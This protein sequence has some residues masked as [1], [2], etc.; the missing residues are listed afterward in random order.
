MFSFVHRRLSVVTTFVIALA[1]SCFSAKAQIVPNGSFENYVAVPTS[2]GGI[3]AGN[4]QNWTCPTTGTSDYFHVLSSTYYPCFSGQTP[5]A[6]PLVMVP[7]NRFGEQFPL[8]VPTGAAYAG[9]Y[10]YDG[11]SGGLGYSEYLT[12]P[13]TIP[14]A[15]NYLISFKASLAEES[16]LALDDIGA[17]VLSSPVSISNDDRI[18]ITTLGLSRVHARSSMLNRI[19]VW[20]DVSGK[21]TA[22]AIGTY[23]R[24][25]YLL[26]GSMSPRASVHLQARTPMAKC[27]TSTLQSNS[28]YYYIDDV[29]I[30]PQTSSGCSCNISLTSSFCDVNDCAWSIT[31]NASAGSCSFNRIIVTWDNAPADQNPSYVVI[32]PSADQTH[33]VN[34]WSINDNQLART[35]PFATNTTLS[36][37]CVFIPNA[38]NADPCTPKIMRFS[39]YNGNN[40]VCEQTMNLGKCTSCP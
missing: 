39:F 40:L 33:P 14:S 11:T 15:G 29:E 18:D 27:V 12:V 34:G 16:N 5:P 6:E 32:G 24:T 10:A 20:T 30:I 36:L 19:D 17:A 9:I 7:G 37:G 13:I 3:Q 21:F 8:P 23:P 2:T 26:I 28:A 38:V 35:A 1:L 31:M 22:P 4:C 25:F